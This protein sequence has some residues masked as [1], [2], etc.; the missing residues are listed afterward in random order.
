MCYYD[1]FHNFDEQALKKLFSWAL[2]LRVDLENLG[3]DSVNKYA[4]G[5]YVDRYSNVIPVFSI[6]CNARVHTE[7]SNLQI[8]VIRSSGH[9]QVGKWEPLYEQL[10]VLNGIKEAN[11]NGQ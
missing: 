1:K 6:I 7:I 2:M 10:L 4:V 11:A 9:A 3:Y 8:K 5:D